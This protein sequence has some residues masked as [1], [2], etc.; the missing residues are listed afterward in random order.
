MIQPAQSLSLNELKAFALEHLGREVLWWIEPSLSS[1]PGPVDCIGW[2]Q[3]PDAEFDEMW[4]WRLPA[5]QVAAVAT[6]RSTVARLVARFL[7]LRGPDAPDA[8]TVG[9]RVTAAASTIAP[10]AAMHALRR[11]AGFAC[12]VFESRPA[13]DQL[14]PL[15]VWPADAAMRAR[16]GAAHLASLSRQPGAKSSAWAMQFDS[17]ACAMWLHAPRLSADPASKRRSQKSSQ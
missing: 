6:K 13:D 1:Q 3:W 15:E 17:A 9:Q 14:K 8:P 2:S 5:E 10:M 7:G 16:H 11:P 12:R 4:A